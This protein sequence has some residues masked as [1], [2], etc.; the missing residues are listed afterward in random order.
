MS[1]TLILPVCRETISLIEEHSTD[2][3]ALARR[4]RMNTRTG[5]LF[6][7]DFKPPVVDLEENKHLILPMLSKLQ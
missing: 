3:F 2:M 4:L 1:N 7:K 6:I 5:K